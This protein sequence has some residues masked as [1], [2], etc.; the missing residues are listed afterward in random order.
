MYAGSEVDKLPSAQT[1]LADARAG[2]VAQ[3]EARGVPARLA[4]AGGMR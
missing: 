4:V 1:C 2:A 3:L